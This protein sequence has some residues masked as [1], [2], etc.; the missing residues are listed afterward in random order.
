[1]SVELKLSW[2]GGF[3]HGFE[4]GLV[5][6]SMYFLRTPLWI[7]SLELVGSNTFASTSSFLTSGRP[8]GPRGSTPPL[9]STVGCAHYDRYVR[10]SPS[11]STTPSGLSC[12]ALSCPGSA[13]AARGVVV[14]TYIVC[15]S[16]FGNSSTVIPPG[17]DG[18]DYEIRF[19]G[20]RRSARD[21][22][23][24]GVDGCLW[25]CPL[26]WRCMTPYGGGEP[27]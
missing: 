9:N 5:L 24:G 25:L 8:R 6:R 18:L 27:K 2:S 3:V 4:K 22:F 14:F 12:F 16:C 1:V 17:G 15:R 19:C 13:H 21:L 20:R 11:N 23:L 26:R 10:P 7:L